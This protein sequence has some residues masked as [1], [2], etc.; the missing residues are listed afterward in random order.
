[1]WEIHFYSHWR[2]SGDMEESRMAGGYQVEVQ[3]LA[4]IYGPVQG[5]LLRAA[6]VFAA[7]NAQSAIVI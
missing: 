2:D 5:T 7:I 3:S 6:D 4:R 1:M